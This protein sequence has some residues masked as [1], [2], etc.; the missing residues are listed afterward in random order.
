MCVCVY[1]YIYIYI[2]MCVCVCVCVTMG[3]HLDLK[4][5]FSTVASCP[6][7]RLTLSKVLEITCK[8]IF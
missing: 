4:A 7:R 5:D 1:I 6:Y 2:Y 3:I 8:P